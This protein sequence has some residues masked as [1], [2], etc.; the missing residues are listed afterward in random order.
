MGKGKKE[1]K[2][3]EPQPKRKAKKKN[4]KKKL[5]SDPLGWR[6]SYTA[7]SRTREEM[8][9]GARIAALLQL[10]LAPRKDD[11]VHVPSMH[12]VGRK[13]TAQRAAQ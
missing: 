5:P 8:K 10:D 9:E 3:F 12:A 4:Q 6:W 2:H 13:C 11:S 7:G 1:G